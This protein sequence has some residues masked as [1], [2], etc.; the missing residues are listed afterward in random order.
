MNSKT[1]AKIGKYTL[2]VV[3]LLVFVRGCFLTNVEAGKIGVR[4]NNAL[5]LL[6]E[7]LKPGWH[8]EILGLQRIWRLPSNYLFL[9]YTGRNTLSI[10]TKDNN[11]VNLDVS[12]PYHIIPGKAY[13]VM[14]AGNHLDAG[15]GAY[16]FERFA[17]DTTISVLREY[18][19][20]LRSQDF[21]NTDRRLEVAKRTLKKLNRKLK[22]LNLQASMIL[23][24]AAYFRPA[25]E[26]QLSQIQLNEQQKL[27]DGAKRKV[28][29]HQQ[30]L[31]NY[32]QQTNAQVSARQQ[33]WTRRIA[34][35]DRAYQVGYVETGE[36][37]APGAARR[38][39]KSLAKDKREEMDKTASTTFSMPLDKVNDAHLLG[40]KNIQAETTEYRERVK[41]AAEGVSAR[42]AA[43]GNARV[44]KV[45]GNYETKL[46][47]LLNSAGG[48]AYVAYK[49][50]N[51]IR[52]ADTLVF[53]SSEGIP[54]ILRLRDFARRFMGR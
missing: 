22:P 16:R 7:D 52:F 32:N 9:S 48:R 13:A 11:T 23:I 53:Q 46:N 47:A 6:E 39:L 21:Y 33:D 19:A 41:A 14:D 17:N 42:L 4:Y 50:A 28:A 24:R 26:R 15:S 5:G 2:L 30:K 38:M 20:Q 1:L 34:N 43:E 49:A 8:L 3:V 12:V 25:Y 31:D 36:D 54:S 40:I 37:R 51:N 29:K 44:A 10:R 35:L 45:K 18:L 27:L